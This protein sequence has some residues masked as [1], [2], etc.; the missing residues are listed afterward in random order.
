[1]TSDFYGEDLAA[2]QAEGFSPRIAEA[3]RW[4]DAQA[5]A[6]PAFDIGCADGA[7]LKCL[8]DQGREVRGCDLSATLV[9]KAR[10][11]G[12]EVQHSDAADADIPPSALI[13]AT[14][15]VL[16]YRNDDGQDALAAAL[17]RIAGALIPGGIFA[18]DLIGPD[19]PEARFWTEGATWFVASDTTIDAGVLTRRIVTFTKN[20]NN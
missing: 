20:T 9:A 10:A 15:E 14:G 16:C 2:I 13:T 11:E 19:V 18:F 1:M 17:P 12:L 4:L 7:L 3:A 5:P 6:G 8:R